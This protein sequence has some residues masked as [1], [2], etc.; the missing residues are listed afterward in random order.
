M[1]VFERYENGKLSVKFGAKHKDSE[2]WDHVL[3]HYY[4]LKFSPAVKAKTKQT[5]ENPK[6]RQRNARKQLSN[7]GIGTKSQQAL[8][9]IQ[10]W[11]GHSNIS[12]TSNVYSHVDS[13]STQ[14][15]KS[16]GV[17]KPL[18]VTVQRLNKTLISQCRERKQSKPLIKSKRACER[19]RGWAHRLC[20]GALNRNKRHF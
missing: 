17:K 14:C 20:A 6:Q 11:L 7:A 5:A 9:L 8:K 10:E 4:K 12:T 15:I 3:K 1:W 16:F 18:D 2:V 19:Q 13:Q